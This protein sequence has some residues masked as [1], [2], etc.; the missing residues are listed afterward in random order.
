MRKQEIH[1]EL[2]ITLSERDRK[3]YDIVKM[4]ARQILRSQVTSL[5]VC[6]KVLASMSVNSPKQ[7]SHL[8]V[9][10]PGRSTRPQHHLQ[11]H[12]GKTALHQTPAIATR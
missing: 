1:T 7:I 9:V 3:G 12:M 10:G 5:M 6:V 11:S 8:L 2:F 4:N